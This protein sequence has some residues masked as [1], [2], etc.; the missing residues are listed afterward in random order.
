MAKTST[1][2]QYVCQNCA[3]I[4]PKWSGRCEVCG[5]WNSLVETAAPASNRQGGGAAAAS[6]QSLTDSMS[7]MKNQYGGDTLVK[8]V[9][10][11]AKLVDRIATN[12]LARGVLLL[13]CGIDGN[14]IRL[15]PPLTI[16]ESELDAGLDILE[17]AMREEAA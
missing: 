9:D 6:V 5:A 11:A 7:S 2:T 17:A 12:A 10:T 15:I 16:P 8:E 3:A 14:V 4:S 1:K 13:S